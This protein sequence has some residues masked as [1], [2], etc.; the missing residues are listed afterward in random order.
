MHKSIVG[1]QSEGST[2]TQSLT[3]NLTV[4]LFHIK[5]PLLALIQKNPSHM[6]V[7][8]GLLNPQINDTL[9]INQSK[10]GGAKRSIATVVLSCET[11]CQ[12]TLL[13][14]THFHSSAENL[15]RFI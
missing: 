7:R 2:L 11:V 15:K 10:G 1:R 5:S 4:G 9:P 8:I 12:Q 3:I 13:R 6:T 14:V